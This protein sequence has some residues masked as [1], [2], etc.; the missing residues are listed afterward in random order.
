MQKP[1]IIYK[2]DQRNVFKN[3]YIAYST[4]NNTESRNDNKSFLDLFFVEDIFLPAAK[5]ISLHYLEDF[6]VLVLPI[7]GGVEIE[8]LQ[9]SDNFIGAEQY[10]WKPKK[11]IFS[12]ANPFEQNE[13]NLLCIGFDNSQLIDK[14]QEFGSI[15]F[16]V[17][18]TLLTFIDF[19]FLKVSIGIYEGRKESIYNKTENCKGIFCFIICG[20]FEVKGRLLHPRDCLSF[21]NEVEIDI[22]ALAENSI[23]LFIETT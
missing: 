4:L 15:D 12:I 16:S 2:A 7:I 14:T 17:K 1:V 3:N 18:N 20:V 23:I 9:I 10:F 8:N 11:E 6:Q 5:K 19:K 13:I 22:E 21:E